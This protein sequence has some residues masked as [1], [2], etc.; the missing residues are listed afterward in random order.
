MSISERAGY[1]WKEE[2]GI[3]RSTLEEDLERLLVGSGDGEARMTL[4]CLGIESEIGV[5][6]RPRTSE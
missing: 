4:M 2:E 1:P 3:L 6:T 5:G